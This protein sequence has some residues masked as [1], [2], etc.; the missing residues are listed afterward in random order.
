MSLNLYIYFFFFT[1]TASF[2]KV[3][4]LKGETKVIKILSMLF[5]SVAFSHSIDLPLLQSEICFFVSSRLPSSPVFSRLRDPFLVALGSPSREA[6]SM[7]AATCLSALD[8]SPVTSKSE[9]PLD[10]SFSI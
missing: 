8:H 6:T 5:S 4:Q 9:E 10:F 7:R 2:F 1:S 3:K